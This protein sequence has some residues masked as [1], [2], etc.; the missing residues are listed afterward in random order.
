MIVKPSIN[1]VQK[2]TGLS[3]RD[4]PSQHYA[5][6]ENKPQIKSTNESNIKFEGYY[7]SD[8]KVGRAS[9]SYDFHATLQNF[10]QPIGQHVDTY[11]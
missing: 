2:H 6:A 8:V 7:V 4:K 3:V 5:Q 10:Q 11:I 9:Q 1:P